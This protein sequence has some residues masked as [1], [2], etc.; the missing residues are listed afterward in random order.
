M[1][2]PHS[3]SV[4]PKSRSVKAMSGDF[5]ALPGDLETAD[6]GFDAVSSEKSVLRID[7]EPLDQRAA[8][9][10]AVGRK[11]R[12]GCKGKGRNPNAS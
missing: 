5:K 11:S 12:L 2:R 6:R 1:F 4:D 10:V 3:P 8:L 9:A 7:C